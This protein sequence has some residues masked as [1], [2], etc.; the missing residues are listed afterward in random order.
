LKLNQTLPIKRI[1]TAVVAIPLLAATIQW[2]GPALFCFIIAVAVGIALFEL[3]DMVSVQA[4][5]SRPLGLAAG[6]IIVS[7][8]QHYRAY[9][10]FESRLYQGNL[11]GLLMTFPALLIFAALL[12][13]LALY[14]RK[15]FL[16]ALPFVGGIGVLYISLFLSYLILL[17][18][19][20]DGK[21]WVF[22]VLIV[23][24]C[25]DSGAYVCG[26][27][28]G[29]HKLSPLVSPN[30]TIEG[31]IGGMVVCLFASVC[32]KMFFLE[33]LSFSQAAVLA[34]VISVSGQAGDLCESTLKRY[35]GFKDSGRVL[36][37]HGGMLDRIDSLLFAA[38]FAY[39]YKML[40]A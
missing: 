24:W 38:P 25:N 26:R 4:A 13:M 34:I 27:T 22:F 28:L 19:G 6:L 2:G 29:R 31:A 5:F 1:T 12:V 36:P 18:N 15:I 39:Y 3:L 16:S 33:H 21:A 23:L 32:A 8:I 10:S 30:K 11:F 37:G 40:I 35:F 14:P 7:L 20:Q 17:Y 9:L